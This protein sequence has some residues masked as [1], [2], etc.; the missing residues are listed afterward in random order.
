MIMASILILSLGALLVNGQRVF[1]AT[2]DSVHKP[3][4][5]DSRRLITA[6]GKEDVRELAMDTGFDSFI[7]KPATHSR[8]FDVIMETFGQSVS[9][10]KEKS[11]D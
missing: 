9:L 10:K 8:L 2:Y 6:F 1:K 3:I 4:H 11:N 7:Q 5:E